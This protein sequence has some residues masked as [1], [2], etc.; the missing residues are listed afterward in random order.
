[1][2]DMKMLK[3]TLKKLEKKKEKLG[4]L[5]I[6]LLLIIFVV[7]LGLDFWINKNNTILTIEGEPK[8]ITITNFNGNVSFDSRLIR[9]DTGYIMNRDKITFIINGEEYTAQ[10]HELKIEFDCNKDIQ[11]QGCQY[12]NSMMTQNNNMYYSTT[13]SSEDMQSNSITI[14]RESSTFEYL[15]NKMNKSFGENKEGKIIMINFIFPREEGL[16][17]LQKN[18]IVFLKGGVVVK[19]KGETLSKTSTELQLKNDSGCSFEF[20]NL[21]NI[22]IM[23]NESEGFALNGT[24]NKINGKFENGNGE[25]FC[26]SRRSQKEFYIGAQEIMADGKSLDV[27]YDFNANS[28]QMSV[29]GHANKAKLE[30]IDVLEGV[31]QFFLQNSTEIFLIILGAFISFGIEKILKK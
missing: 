23:I 29:N 21:S 12:I 25:M 7:V 10:P 27:D 20:E 16:L 4:R 8:N 26:T 18:E 15:H 11:K 9:I 19:Y 3:N 28:A 5:K 17:Q 2:N 6:W 14:E 1:M 30:D 24:I 13:V 31:G 22:E